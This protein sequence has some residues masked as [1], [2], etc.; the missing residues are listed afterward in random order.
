MVQYMIHTY[1]I[2]SSGVVVSS[3]IL[4]EIVLEYIAVNSKLNRHSSR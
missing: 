3:E 1:L 4:D 2:I